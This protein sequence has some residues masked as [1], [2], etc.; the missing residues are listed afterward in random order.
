MKIS[1]IEPDVLAAS[2]IPI[3]AKDLQSLH[4]Q[5]VR[6]II[7]LT[8]QPVTSFKSISPYE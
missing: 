4:D 2:A 5:G 1:W 3:D 8:E 7:S 6:A